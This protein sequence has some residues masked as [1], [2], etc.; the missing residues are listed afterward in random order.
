[1]CPG[2]NNRIAHLFLSSCRMYLKHILN[3]NLRISIPTYAVEQT[4]MTVRRSTNEM[5]L[6]FKNDAR[7]LA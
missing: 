4:K 2:Q 7:S 3:T 6:I 5:S 1:M